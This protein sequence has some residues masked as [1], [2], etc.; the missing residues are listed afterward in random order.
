[1]NFLLII[2]LLLKKYSES[3]RVESSGDDAG[4]ESLHNQPPSSQTSLVRN[5]QLQRNPN[6]QHEPRYASLGIDSRK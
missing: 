5:I 6:M 2:F 4:Y 1:M 3:H